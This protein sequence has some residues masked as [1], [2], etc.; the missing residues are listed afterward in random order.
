MLCSAR[1]VLGDS[2]GRKSGAAA[3]GRPE[4]ACGVWSQALLY[5]CG[6]AGCL[7]GRSEMYQM[8]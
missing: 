4:R 6:L 8:A 3:A 2:E 7:W 1:G 5:L